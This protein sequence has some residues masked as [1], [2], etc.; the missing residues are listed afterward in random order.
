[1]RTTGTP[2]ADNA[3]LSEWAEWTDCRTTPDAFDALA[4]RRRLQRSVSEFWT[5]M[6]TAIAAAITTANARVPEALRVE[7]GDTPTGGLAL[8]RWTTYPIAFLDVSVD[9]Q[10]GLLKCAYNFA[11]RAG[12]QYGALTKSWSIRAE[13]DRLIVSDERGAHAPEDV[14]QEIVDVYLSKL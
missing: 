13:N 3:V 9:E 6:K 10:H 1:M 8:T 2:K 14:V 11:A 12:E 4:E 5:H 7:T